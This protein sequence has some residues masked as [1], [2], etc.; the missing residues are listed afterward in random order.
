VTGPLVI[1]VGGNALVGAG[2]H[3]DALHQ[4]AALSDAGPALAAAV[5]D[6]PVVMTHGNGPQVGHLGAAASAGGD[7]EPLDVL[8]ALSQGLI[9]YLLEE[10]LSARLPDRSVVG[11][12]T[13]VEVDPDDPA[14]A[15]PTKP[16]GPRGPGRRLVPSP[17]P[18]RIVELDA[19]A[20]LV[21][22]G[23]LVVAVGG[24][25]VPVVTGA[26]GVRRGVEAVVDKDLASSLLAVG[27]DAEALVLLTDVDAV[28]DRW[29]TAG[30]RPLGRVSV[31]DL[32]PDA[33]EAG[34]MAPKV[35]AAVRFVRATGRR[36]AIGA[37]AQAADV[38]A[39]G[40]GTQIRP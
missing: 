37:L 7:P 21:R 40:R 15:H 29:G 20:T 11:V 12:L 5:G 25:G 10:E 36:A 30:A 33:F 28:V 2:D 22:A 34:T 32:D 8:D 26:D 38:V 4:R 14:F 39:G 23:H 24:G 9:G 19:I 3:V 13:R 31:G 18:R 1:A 35:A 6:R 16:V 17:E 27:L